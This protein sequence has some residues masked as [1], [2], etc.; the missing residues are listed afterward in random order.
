MSRNSGPGTRTR[1]QEREA[2]A[3]ANQLGPARAAPVRSVYGVR[4][5]FASLFTDRGP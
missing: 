4:P 2:G 3:D 1:T 5:D